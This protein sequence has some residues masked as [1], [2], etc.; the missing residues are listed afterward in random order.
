MD[1][2]TGLITCNLWRNEDSLYANFPDLELGQLVNVQGKLNT[3]RNEKRINI[4]HI[5]ILCCLLLL[6]PTGCEEDLDA[7]S[8]RWL[9]I[10]HLTKN[11]YVKWKE[12]EKEQ[13]VEHTE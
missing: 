8:L 1:D 2:G 5:R 9:E 10:V 4:T 6:I 12:S 7:E 11:Y 3:F 13:N